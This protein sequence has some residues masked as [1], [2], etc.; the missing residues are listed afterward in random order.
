M[1][2]DSDK[3][4][5]HDESSHHDEEEHHEPHSEINE[6][7]NEELALSSIHRKHVECHWRQVLRKEKFQELRND[8]ESLQNYHQQNIQQKKNVL[9]SIQSE[10]ASLQQLYHGA[11]VA[12]INYMEG[13]IAIHDEQVV[14]LEKS[15]HDRLSS[16]QAEFQADI[17]KITGQYDK[18]TDVVQQC[19]NRHREK[20][21]RRNELLQL[22]Q[23]RELDEIETRHK[24]ESTHIQGHLDAAVKH[25]QEQFEQTHEEYSQKNHVTRKVYEELKLKDDEVKKMIRQTTRR[26]DR[27]QNKVQRI[28]LLAEKEKAQRQ[29][30]HRALLDRKIRALETFQLI[31]DDMT[32]FRKNQQEKL[33]ALSRRANERK[34]SL[35]KQSAVAERVK[36]IADRCHQLETSKEQFATILRELSSSQFHDDTGVAEL[37]SRLHQEASK[38]V[39]DQKKAASKS[40][41]I[42]SS[43]PNKQRALLWDITHRFWDKYNVAQV[44]VLT[45][46]KRI[47]ELKRKEA[48][49]QNKLTICRNGVTVNDDVLKE[50]NPL[51]VINGKMNAYAPEKT[52]KKRLTVIEGNHFL[53]TTQ[54][55]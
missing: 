53:A 48:D 24:K 52:R 4:D 54:I 18:E 5:C 35:Q 49:L 23:Q 31:K 9:Q 45:I 30:R 55:R 36:K 21:Q 37:D 13:M 50:R 25:F 11:M 40:V 15:F 44:D 34:E 2:K 38:M 7:I 10:T 8:I 33:V 12:N 39:A 41:A 14:L 42:V 32:E 51:L 1:N 43:G 29:D 22:E 46:Q 27:I 17:V 19:I 16:M 26:A 47:A 28:Q 20:E 6:R 3:G